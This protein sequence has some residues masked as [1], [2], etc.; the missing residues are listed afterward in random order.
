[1]SRR[2]VFFGV[3]RALPKSRF[4]SLS[5]GHYNDVNASQQRR[6]SA[7]SSIRLTSRSCAN[8]GRGGFT[9]IPTAQAMPHSLC[10]AWGFFRC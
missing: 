1:M 2:L 8:D 10:E 6:Q 9:R 4:D 5:C 3:T 7:V